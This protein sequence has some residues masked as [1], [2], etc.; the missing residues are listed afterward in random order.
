MP[1]TFRDL[2]EVVKKRR[3]VREA[4]RNYL[5]LSR[6]GSRSFWGSVSEEDEREL[7]NL[8]RKAAAFP[9]PIIEIGALFGFT[10]QLFATYKPIEKKL[11]AVESFA[12]N[13]FGIPAADHRVITQRVLRYNMT[14]CNTSLFDGPSQ[15][16]YKTYKGERPAMVF[17]DAGHSYEAVKEDIAW[18]E[19]AD[20][21]LIVGHDYNELWPG[22]KRAVDEAFG[23]EIRVRG[24]VWSHT[25]G[26]ASDM[27]DGEPHF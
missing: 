18:A 7:V 11:I 8:T 1:M 16:F 19:Q 13:P 17:I 4:V 9:G 2:I 20:I 23:A 15:V 5:S 6:H 3:G 26:P 24:S 14:H 27:G 12:W 21:P 22:V 25:A 10:T